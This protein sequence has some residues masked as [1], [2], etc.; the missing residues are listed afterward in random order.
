[1]MADLLSGA[2]RR[3]WRRSVSPVMGLSG[4]DWS[5]SLIVI[6]NVM[7]GPENTPAK[8]DGSHQ[9]LPPTLLLLLLLSPLILLTLFLL[10]L[11][12]LPFFIYLVL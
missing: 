5:G 8:T 2:V 10:F 9:Q 1:M 7:T 12:S 3:W 4:R 6:C 11:L